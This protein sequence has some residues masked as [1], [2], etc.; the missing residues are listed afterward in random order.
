MGEPNNRIEN[1]DARKFSMAG[2]EKTL[3]G[4]KNIGVF[5]FLATLPEKT[6]GKNRK[7]GL[8][9]V[10]A[11]SLRLPDGQFLSCKFCARLSIS[12]KFSSISIINS[13]PWVSLIKPLLINAVIN[14]PAIVA[15]DLCIPLR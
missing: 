14:S 7:G 13:I 5:L 3:R 15:S 10:L 4:S 12:L 2:P 8:N 11:S 1:K 9:R 6:V